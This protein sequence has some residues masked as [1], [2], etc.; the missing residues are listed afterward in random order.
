MVLVEASTD[1]TAVV[2]A[3]VENFERVNGFLQFAEAKNG[4][5]LVVA[6][7]FAAM[8]YDQAH[9]GNDFETWPLLEVLLF[10]VAALIY[11]VSF[12]PRLQPINILC[13]RP[14]VEKNLLFFGHVAE[15]PTSEFAKKFRAGYFKSS[16]VGEAFYEDLST[17]VSVNSR[18]CLRKMKLFKVGSIF[19]SVGALSVIARVLCAILS[20]FGGLCGICL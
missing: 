12:L 3:Q 4:A 17:Q 13:E 15:I 10:L 1:L 20:N 18:I 7:G 14:S 16:R 19:V 2:A 11:A 9:V 6:A 8:V 5:G